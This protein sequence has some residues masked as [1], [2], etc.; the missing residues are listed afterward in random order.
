MRPHQRFFQASIVNTSR[1]TLRKVL[2]HGSKN[3]RGVIQKI[4]HH[5]FGTVIETCGVARHRELVQEA[6]AQPTGSQPRIGRGLCR[7]VVA[8]CEQQRGDVIGDGLNCCAVGFSGPPNRT[9]AHM[10]IPCIRRL[11]YGVILQIG[12]EGIGVKPT[13]GTAC[14]CGLLARNT[15]RRGEAGLP[16]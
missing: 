1:P 10:V 11:R 5:G 3:I 2:T 6:V 7:I 15:Y 13:G 9:D 12:I 4:S 8:A 14:P 16:I